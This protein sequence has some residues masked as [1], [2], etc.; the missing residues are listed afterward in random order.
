[1]LEVH[2]LFR[3]QFG[4]PPT[5]TVHAPSTVELLGN[6][7]EFHHGLALFMAVDR[8]A[9]IAVA[10]RT[11]GKV[12]IATTDASP[13]ETFSILETD[14]RSNSP[15]TRLVKSML[16]AL[17]Q[18][19]ANCSGFSAA[20]HN[21]I[22]GEAGLG[23]SAALM[24]ATALAV[25][26]LHPFTLTATGVTVPPKRAADGALPPLSTIEKIEIARTCQLAGNTATSEHSGLLAPVASLFSKA[27][28]AV[29]IDCQSF[30]IESVPL[31]GEIAWVLCDT[32]I[33]H[34]EIAKVLTDLHSE[35]DAATRALGLKSLRSVDVSFLNANRQRLSERQFHCACHL[36]G[37]T[38]RV[39]AATR[40]LRDGDF[41]QFGQ[42]MYQSHESSR[43]LFGNSCAELDEL[44][45][46]ARIHPGCLG[47]RLTGHGFGGATLNLVHRAQA[48]SF[49]KAIAAVY[50][51]RTG[52]K[53]TPLI[54]KPA[55]GAT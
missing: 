13:P 32:G 23:D 49:A 6:F 35:C 48:E 20:I 4:H 18:R 28:H 5:Y 16:H 3:N 39:V 43:D 33:R 11:D 9:S 19:Q 1:M 17:R 42:F 15:Q 37:E 7:A 34:A 24:I 47:A 55:D 21:T 53:I 31:I 40:A 12:V 27:F 29:E 41:A 51:K 44:V 22:P 10:A 36:V 38:Q 14:P 2:Q 46:L 30:T 26:Q 25:R 52:R 8:A 45:A 50:E 54:C